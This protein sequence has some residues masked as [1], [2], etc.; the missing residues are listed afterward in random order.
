[1]GV[2]TQRTGQELLRWFCGLPVEKDAMGGSKLSFRLLLDWPGLRVADLLGRT[3]TLLN[4]YC[5]ELGRP[6]VIFSPPPQSAPPTVGDLMHV[7]DEDYDIEY[8]D[9]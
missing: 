2:R 9:D 8:D 3:P 4:T 5:G 7:T 6:T 1:M